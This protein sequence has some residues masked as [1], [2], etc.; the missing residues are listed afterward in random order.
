MKTTP[1]KKPA[2]KKSVPAKTAAPKTAPARAGVP[3]QEIRAMAKALGIPSFGKTKTELIRSI[4]RA[5]GN[6]DCYA[7]AAS[8]YCDQTA[9][10][11]HAD[12]MEESV[13]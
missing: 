7:T 6:F 4:Q 10:R 11:W 3:M 13:K 2:V 12:C 8:G 5:E 1:G 9:C